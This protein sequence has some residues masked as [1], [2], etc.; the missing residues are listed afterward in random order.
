LNGVCAKTCNLGMTKNTSG[1]C[2]ALT[3]DVSH[4]GM[5]DVACVMTPGPDANG[6]VSC[7]N[8]VCTKS[9]KTGYKLNTTDKV[10]VK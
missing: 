4:C 2:F 8:G 10:C 9:C 3:T 6:L 5:A 1:K 7:V